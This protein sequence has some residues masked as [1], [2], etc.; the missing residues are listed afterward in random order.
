VS[1]GG[2]GSAWAEELASVLAAGSASVSGE[3]SPSALGARLASALA[4]L[5]EPASM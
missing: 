5:L 3:A 4:W 2:S 1:G